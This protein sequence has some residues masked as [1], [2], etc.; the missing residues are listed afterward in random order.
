MASPET[1]E[2]RAAWYSLAFALR[3]TSAS[4][5]DVEPTELEGGL[6]VTAH[7]GVA[8]ARA[9]LSDRLENG[10]GYASHLALPAVFET[11]L[12]EFWARVQPAWR[13]HGGGCD[14]SCA[15]CLRDYVNLPYHPIL[16]W[17][18]AEDMLKI[19]ATP[20]TALHLT[21]SPW[22]PLI[23]GD[24]APIRRSLKELAFEP[25]D[26]EGRLPT[27]VYEANHG[28][29]AVVVRHPL[30]TDEHPSVLRAVAHV[31]HELHARRV[32][33]MSPFMLLRRPTEVL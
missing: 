32:T 6:Y 33:V 8:S 12:H 20:D 28:T 10:A 4:L 19:I 29:E 22:E 9:F 3:N 30:W 2:G 11:M 31:E 18:L 7:D 23:T 13:E 16:D 5:L 27:F 26:P 25:L 24:D 21:D 14:A 1:V 17:R 15:R